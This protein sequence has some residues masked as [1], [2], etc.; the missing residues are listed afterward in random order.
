MDENILADIF[1]EK[2]EVP[3]ELKRR[4]HKE[5]IKQEKKIMIRN[6]VVAL[7]AVFVISFFI[8]TF[9]VVFFNDIVTIL[10]TAILLVVYALMAVLLAGVI[11]KMEIM[12][13][14]KGIL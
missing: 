4:I 12:N 1:K 7:F 13:I 11:G 3:E 9:V 10:C 2:S 6:V 14:Q 5:L 8:I